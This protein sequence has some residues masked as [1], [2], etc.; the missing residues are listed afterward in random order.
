MRK[1]LL[2]DFSIFFNGG[3]LFY[4]VFLFWYVTNAVVNDF[5][6]R[7]LLVSSD[8]RRQDKKT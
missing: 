6:G 4:A 1:W 7:Y 3:I 8:V 5:L 2:N